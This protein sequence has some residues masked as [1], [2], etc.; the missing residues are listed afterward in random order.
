MMKVFRIYF[1]LMILAALLSACETTPP[2]RDSVSVADEGI[3]AS[4]HNA[5]EMLI[6]RA[7]SNLVANGQ[8]LI[9]ASFVDINDLERT[10]PFG[11]IVSQQVATYFT[12]KG[13]SVV[14]ML[15]RKNIYIK[16]QQGE[17]LLSRELRNISAEHNAQAV[18]AGTYAVGERRV[19]VTAK[20]VNSA[21]SVA[22]SSYD[23]AMPL[24]P[25]TKDLLSI[26]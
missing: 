13:Y 9:V 4:S 18:I 15:L 10:S 26:K 12:S 7:G 11:R 17:F 16:Q 3:I 21:S 24:G 23:Y 22:L 1:G 8:P 14:E 2:E 5:A 20:L 19:Y 25:D 6:K